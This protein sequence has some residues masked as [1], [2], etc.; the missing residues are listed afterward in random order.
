MRH[1][2]VEGFVHN[3][4]KQKYRWIYYS[5]LLLHVI[6]VAMLTCLALLINNPTSTTCECLQQLLQI[7]YLQ[8]LIHNFIAL[9]ACTPYG[10]GCI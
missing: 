3:I 9:H 4:W 7:D 8:Q 1:P 2:I 10:T 5:S 6:F